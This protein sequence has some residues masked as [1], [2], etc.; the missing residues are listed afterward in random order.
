MSQPISVKI[1]GAEAPPANADETLHPPSR[2]ELDCL[3]K[4]AAY[5][6]VDLPVE[7][8]KHTY[9]IDGAPISTTQ[10]LRMAKDA[11]LRAQNAQLDWGALFRLG[12]AYPALVRLSNGNWIV[13]LHAGH[14]AD[15]VEAVSVFDPLAGGRDEP[16]IV[17]KDLFCGRWTGDVILIKRERLAADGRPAFGLRWFVPELLRQWRLF[18]D[19]AIA[20]ILLY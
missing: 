13:V 15:G 6:G 10:L 3:A 11:G 20:A 14:G 5:H 18:A 19:V 17:H 1:E 9:A 2:T 7:R 16:L 8:L 4:I 12:E